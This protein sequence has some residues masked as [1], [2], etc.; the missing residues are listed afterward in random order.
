MSLV[1]Q[2][3]NKINRA[4][5]KAK[6]N[7]HKVLQSGMERL[8]EWGMMECLKAHDERHRN[9]F[10]MGDGYGWILY[11]DKKEV[12]KR[13]YD[14][15]YHMKASN[16]L[17][18]DIALKEYVVEDNG[19]VGVIMASMSPRHYFVK[20]KEIEFMQIAISNIEGLDFKNIFIQA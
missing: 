4:F 14:G 1:S 12:S 2:N 17:S 9:H 8:L 3:N 13:I 20:R 18:V 10:D 11:K 7:V 5:D 6:L 19:W 15:G 16:I